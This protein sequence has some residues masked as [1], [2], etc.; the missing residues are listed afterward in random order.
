MS[1]DKQDF[2]EMVD[3]AMSNPA[4]SAMRPVVE[5]EL[6]HYQIFQALDAEGLLRNLVFQGGTS[7]RLCRGSDR[8][9]EDLDFVGG[10]DFSAAS[11]QRIKECVEQRIGAR[12]GLKVM[13]N[14]KPAKVGED[15][16][17]HVRVDKWWISIETSPENP[18]MPRQKIKLEITNIPAHTREL[19][20]LRANYEFLNGMSTVL[21][22]AESLDEIMADKVLAFP[23]SLLDNAG[24]PVGSDS[25]KIRHR[26][27]WD[28]AWMATRGAKLVPGL[29]AAKIGDYGVV[30]YPGLLDYAIKQL[31]EIVNSRE[32]KAQMSRFVD[33]ATVAKTLD[34]ESYIGYLAMEVGGLFTQMKAALGNTPI[35][36]LAA[37][38]AAKEKPKVKPKRK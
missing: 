31:P 6:L 1:S 25:A 24:Q 10:R 2:H 29:V 8:F 34:T 17:K 35:E 20:P 38:Y 27:I 9:S 12:F 13:V 5:K 21:V 19:T 11:M 30:N 16:V 3:R 37:S 7:L 4:L 18:A 14:N 32:F 23:T 36:Q 15:G 26:D 33:S 22:N 28:L